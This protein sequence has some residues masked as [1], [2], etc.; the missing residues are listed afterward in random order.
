[1]RCGHRSHQRVGPDPD[2]RSRS[3]TT[4]GVLRW[5]RARR[6]HRARSR[7]VHRA[8]RGDRCGACRDRAP[9]P[10][11]WAMPPRTPGPPP[12]TD[13]SPGPTRRA[14][15][16]R[17]RSLSTA[18][19]AISS[20]GSDHVLTTQSSSAQRQIRLA[21]T[22]VTGSPA[23]AKSPDLDHTPAHD[24]PPECHTPRNPPH[25][26][27]SRPPTTTARRH[28]P[29]R[30]RRTRRVLPTPSRRHYRQSPSGASSC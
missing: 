21:H 15:S 2:R 30:T 9:R 1:M 3:P 22:N 4:S 14:I 27:W 26:R 7:W 19:G 16:A 23:I 24:R 12:R 28:E 25:P 29:E 10:W 6:S 13:S 17:A 20:E 11:R 5:R 18:R 8:S